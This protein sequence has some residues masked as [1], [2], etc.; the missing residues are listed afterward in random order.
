M[1]FLSLDMHASIAYDLKDIF[2]LLGHEVHAL[3][4]SGHA[5]VNGWKQGRTSVVTPENWRAIDQAMCDRFAETYG[6][7][8]EEYDGFI[9]SYPPAFALLFEKL[10]KPVIVHNCTRFEH[11]CEDRLA[12]LKAGLSNMIQRGQLIPVAN[13][14]YD[15][16]YATKHTNHKWEFIP[17][18]CRYAE[19][20]KWTGE[21]SVKVW[22]RPN[23]N[24]PADINVDR[25]FSILN[26]Y[27]RASIAGTTKAVVH[28]PYNISIMSAFEHRASGIPMLVPSVN[29]LIDMKNDG[30]PLLSELQFPGGLPKEM[31]WLKLA[32]WYN[33]RGVRQFDSFKHLKT[34]L[35]GIERKTWEWHAGEIKLGYEEDRDEAITQW[36]SILDAMSEKPAKLSVDD[37]T[38]RMAQKAELNG[39]LHDWSGLTDDRSH[40]HANDFKGYSQLP[41]DLGDVLEIGCGPFTQTRTILRGRKASRVV[42]SDPLAVEYKLKHPA[43]AYKTDHLGGQPVEVVP[44]SGENL[45][46]SDDF[47]TVIL[48]NVL[49]HVQDADAVMF[50]AWE[51]LRPGGLLVCGER[52]H[53]PDEPYIN[54]TDRQLHPIRPQLDFFDRH[55]ARYTQVY[56]KDG[57]FVG[58]KPVSVEVTV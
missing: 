54:S 50:K 57:Y 39:W 52:I 20:W 13:N 38:W 12:W 18:V 46:F 24:L 37:E 30:Y 55:Y 6:K 42:L 47:D 29:C 11:P 5:W 49:E 8:L 32:D 58:R 22:S 53:E 14:R 35:D 23:I 25:G 2:S 9:V 3:S 19:A 4:M 17:S 44:M 40:E 36:K 56:R 10:G 1:K 45:P 43:C 41:N 15:A 16:E 28:L 31:P 48:I 51:A 34:M 21:G 26:R 7:A 27:D 33:W